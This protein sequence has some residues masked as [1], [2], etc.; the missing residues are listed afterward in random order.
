MMMWAPA[1]RGGAFDCVR[2]MHAPKLRQRLHQPP[3]IADVQGPAAVGAV[4]RSRVLGPE[5]VHLAADVVAGIRKVAVP[6]FHPHAVLLVQ[7]VHLLLQ[8]P[9]APAKDLGLRLTAQHDRGFDSNRVPKTFSM[10]IFVSNDPQAS[11]G[12]RL[13]LTALQKKL[14]N[15]NV[16]QRRRLPIL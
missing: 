5:L 9:C 11:W 1:C 7:H 10:C 2:R 8:P 16:D 3:H 12:I 15:H 6:E 14:Q 13:T 4:P